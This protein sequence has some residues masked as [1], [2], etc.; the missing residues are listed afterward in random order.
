MSVIF[1]VLMKCQ[2]VSISVSDIHQATIQMYSCYF[3]IIGNLRHQFDQFIKMV[4]GQFYSILI[5]FELFSSEKC[6]NAS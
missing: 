4:Y 3:L 5:E 2:I 6:L 1:S